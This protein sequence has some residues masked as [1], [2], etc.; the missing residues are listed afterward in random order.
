MTQTTH[1]THTTE[2]R[3]A[4]ARRLGVNRSTV[5]RAVQDGRL[6]LTDTGRVLVEPSLRRW[7]ETKGGRT[8]V[9][10]R[11]ADNRGAEIPEAVGGSENAAAA[12]DARRAAK[13]GERKPDAK[14]TRARFKAMALDFENQS[15]RL[16]I[17][18]RQYQRYPLAAIE[19][20]GLALGGVVRSVLERLI[21]QTAPR[22][23]I[24]PG[25]ERLRVIENEM[26]AARQA[27]NGE[28]PRALRR[29]REKERA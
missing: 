15:I 4:F 19:K 24:L 11:H 21:D 29:L 27:V 13:G 6:V 23:A 22:L 16:E 26:R 7:H 28:F 20:E 25:A 14:E 9:E 5:T 2:S 10:A 17:A 18:L 12:Q 3:A 8:D 1:T